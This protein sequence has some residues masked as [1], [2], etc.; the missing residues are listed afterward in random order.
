MNKCYILKESHEIEKLLKYKYSVG[1]KYFVIYYNKNETIKVAFSAS[2][3]IG[4][5]V[6]RNYNKRTM[7][8]IVRKNMKY[9][10]KRKALV[11]IKQAGALLD[12]QEKENQLIKLLKKIKVETNE[13][14]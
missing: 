1:N 10:E 3:K 14:I 6:T 2:K 11:V 13:I 7:R 8:E 4:N 12:Y 5:A 9:L